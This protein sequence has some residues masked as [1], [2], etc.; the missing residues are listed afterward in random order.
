MNPMLR[1]EIKASAF[2]RMTRMMAPGKDEPAACGGHDMC[3]RIDAWDKWN[4]DHHDVIEAMLWAFADQ[5]EA[6][7]DP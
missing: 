2:H 6:N 4:T 1:F 5:T 7:D 3:D